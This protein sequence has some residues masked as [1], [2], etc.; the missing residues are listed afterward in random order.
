MVITQRPPASP[1]SPFPRLVSVLSATSALRKTRAKSPTDLFASRFIPTLFNFQLSTVNSH[2]SK[3]H[4]IISFADP[5]HLTLIESHSYKKQGEGWVPRDV[6]NSA[7]S[8]PLFFTASKHLA[9]RNPHNSFSFHA[10]T[11]DSLDTRGTP[12]PTLLIRHSPLR[13]LCDLSEAVK[14]HPCGCFPNIPTPTFLRSLNVCRFASLLCV[15]DYPA[16]AGSGARPSRIPCC[17]L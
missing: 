13:H 12:H 1:H 4:R 2:S 11:Y 6:Q 9:H 16:G 5:H 3:S 14:K 7:Q 8:L 15:L 10:L 17:M